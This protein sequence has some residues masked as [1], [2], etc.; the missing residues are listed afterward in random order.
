MTPCSPISAIFMTMIK[1]P[2][3][4]LGTGS[5]FKPNHHIQL[6]ALVTNT[7]R[8]INVIE[9]QNSTHASGNTHIIGK[10]PDCFKRSKS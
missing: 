10:Q 8:Q 5:N 6:I 3:V 1:T 4:F 2:E 7:H 9:K